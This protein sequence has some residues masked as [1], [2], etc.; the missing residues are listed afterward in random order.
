MVE[1]LEVLERVVM[2]VW[3]ARYCQGMGLQDDP[4]VGLALV[5]VG[6]YAD[7]PEIRLKGMEN[8]SLEGLSGRRGLNFGRIDLKFCMRVRGDPA[9]LLVKRSNLIGRPS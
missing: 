4:L 9:E 2:G 7:W 5:D 3:P 6:P 1:G 8:V